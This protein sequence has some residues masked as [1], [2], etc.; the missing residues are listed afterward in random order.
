ME[1]PKGPRRGHLVRV[2]IR[3]RTV[4]SF[5]TGRHSVTSKET[6]HP[7]KR[8]TRRKEEKEW[9]RTEDEGLVVSRHSM[10]LYE[11]ETGLVSRSRGMGPSRPKQVELTY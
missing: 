10:S 3:P 1:L 6:R 4:V 11:V 2:Q 7:R 9:K 8:F 5:D